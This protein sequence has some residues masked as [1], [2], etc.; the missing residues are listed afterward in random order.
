VRTNAGSPLRV[1]LASKLLKP[2]HLAALT[3]FSHV[4]VPIERVNRQCFT[5]RKII[6]ALVLR[7]GGAPQVNEVKGDEAVCFLFRR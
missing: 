5:W 6:T 2:F 4:H 7:R 1:I 3:G